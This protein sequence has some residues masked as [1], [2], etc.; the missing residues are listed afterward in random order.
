MEKKMNLSY[1][2]A[3]GFKKDF[4]K[5]IK[6]FRTLDEDLNTAKKSAIELLHI[7]DIDNKSIFAIP[8]FCN[9]SIKIYKLKKIACKALKGRGK[10]SGLRLIYA[11]H[12]ADYR[13]VL[14]EIYF[15]GDKENEDKLRIG[16][17]LSQYKI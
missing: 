6:K 5:L 9:D 10:L 12:T 17:Y 1:E 14:I 15:K 16:A 11:F 2:E 8:G 4:K 7:N 13:V 3:V